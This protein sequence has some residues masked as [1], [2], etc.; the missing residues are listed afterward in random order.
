ML[1]KPSKI[2]DVQLKAWAVD[3]PEK[4]A[5][6]H[7]L[8]GGLYF[9]VQASGT[10]QFYFR[11]KIAG[12]TR[13]HLVGVYGEMG[14]A[15]ARKE[16]EAYR[17]DLRRGVDP[18]AERAK[19][20]AESE[21][22][23]SFQEVG[24]EWYER[25]VQPQ[26][27]HPEVTERVLRRWIFPKIGK[28]AVADVLPSD[29]DRV[30]SAIVRGGAPTVANDA[31]RHMVQIFKYA[32]KRRLIEFNPAADFDISDAGG[33]ERPRDRSLDRAEIKKLFQAMR[34]DETFGRANEL[35]VKLLLLLGARKMELLSA[36]W[37]AIDLDVGEW[38]VTTNKSDRPIVVPLPEL[39]LTWL[40]ELKGYAGHSRYVFP[41]RR[42][43]KQKRFPHIGPDTLNMAVKDLNHEV[44]HFTI[45]D[46]RRTARTHLARLG[47]AEVIA[48]RCLNHAVKGVVGIY[49]RH[50]YLEER[51]EA[52]ELWAAD[53]QLLERGDDKVVPGDFRRRA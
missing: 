26:L 39:A 30:L 22:R 48:E 8:G 36:E 52:L 10:C 38:T 17:V 12:R 42:I 53:L 40:Q 33:K 19:A 47:V 7:T 14:L 28:V 32:K 25:L 35:A 5:A 50:D 2:T 45:H 37:D 24:T 43:S 27:K 41:A 51:R 11:Y 44:A 23:R 20:K 29:V 1:E 49:D 16:V 15:D 9:R 6:N 13:W 4:H 3:V 46:L 31:L 34:K 21:R 18:A